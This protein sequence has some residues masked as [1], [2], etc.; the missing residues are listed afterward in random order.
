ML[1]TPEQ[2]NLT[3]KQC[4]KKLDNNDGDINKTESNT[5]E[6]LAGSVVSVS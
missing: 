4:R 1:N 6:R 2:I 5:E 3:G